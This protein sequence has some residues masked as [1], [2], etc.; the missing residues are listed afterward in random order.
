MAEEPVKCREPFTTME[1]DLPLHHD[2]DHATDVPLP[3]DLRLFVDHAFEEMDRAR[4][5][6]RRWRRYYMAG[7]GLWIVLSFWQAANIFYTPQ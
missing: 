1:C 7:L 6:F 2:G 3:P 5:S 4:R